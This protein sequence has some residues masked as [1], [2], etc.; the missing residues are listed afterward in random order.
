MNLVTKKQKYTDGFTQSFNQDKHSRMARNALHDMF[1]FFA[2]L[3]KEISRFEQEKEKTA[4][5]QKVLESMHEV[6]NCYQ[7]T[8]L[9]L[10][11]EAQDIKQHA[12][13]RFSDALLDLMKAIHRQKAEL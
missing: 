1:D 4:A 9:D 8:M 7:Q 13:T 2:N 11:E 3:E 6:R 12:L 5:D 10:K